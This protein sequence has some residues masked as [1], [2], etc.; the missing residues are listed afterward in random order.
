[1]GFVD[2][3]EAE[4]VNGGEEGGAGA[5]DD[6]WSTISGFYFVESS[7]TRSLYV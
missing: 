4:V 7:S 2:D 6:E 5:Y 1:M 3:D